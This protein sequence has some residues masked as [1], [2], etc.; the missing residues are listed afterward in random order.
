M[1]VIA[2]RRKYVNDHYNSNTSKSHKE[3]TYLDGSS[4]HITNSIVL[5][6]VVTIKKKVPSKSSVQRALKRPTPQVLSRE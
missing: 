6:L 1:L 3:G 5:I 4:S 2:M